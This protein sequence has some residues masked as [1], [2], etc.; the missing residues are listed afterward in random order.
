MEILTALI[1]FP[2]EKNLQFANYNKSQF[3]KL[4]QRQVNYNFLDSEKFLRE[5]S[6]I[7]F[8]LTI[9]TNSKALCFERHSGDIVSKIIVSKTEVYSLCYTYV[10][11]TSELF[12]LL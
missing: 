10:A 9:N 11:Q 6:E 12:Q 7:N 8:K 5:T 2:T 4:W 3:F 1:I